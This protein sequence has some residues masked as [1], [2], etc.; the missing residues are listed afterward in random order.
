MGNQNEETK[1]E[2]IFPIITPKCPVCGSTE[3]VAQIVGEEEAAKGKLP[4][5]TPISIQTSVSFIA[6]MKAIMLTIGKITILS[7]LIDICAN[8]HAVYASRIEKVEKTNTEVQKMM[9]IQALPPGHRGQVLFDERFGR[10][11]GG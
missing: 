8:C 9:G 7:S 2:L 11:Q 6:D 1:Q 10:R 3:R 4:K 5:G